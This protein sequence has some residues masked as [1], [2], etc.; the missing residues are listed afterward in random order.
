HFYMFTE[1]DN[2]EE[3][4]LSIRALLKEITKCE[5]YDGFEKSIKNWWIKDFVLT[6]NDIITKITELVVSP[7]ILPLSRENHNEKTQLIE[8]AIMKFDVTIIEDNND[9]SNIWKEVDSDH[10]FESSVLKNFET[11]HGELSDE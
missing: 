5:V 2:F 1:Q 7:F 10:D 3:V 4:E 6:K 11:T 9:I 8:E